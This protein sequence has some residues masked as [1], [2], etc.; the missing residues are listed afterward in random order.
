MSEILIRQ[1]STQD[2]EMVLELARVTFWDAFASHPK[3][4]P[5]DTDEYMKQAFDPERIAGQLAD[6]TNVFLIAEIDGEPAGYARLV[7]DYTE[8][9]VRA[10]RPIELN[11][12]Y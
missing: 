1:A 7:R 4:A 12:L 9:G 8:P 11:R 2:A 5:H 6:P 10:E 3:N